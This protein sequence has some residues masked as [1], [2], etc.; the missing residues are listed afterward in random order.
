[1]T[2]VNKSDD[3]LLTV[4][5][6]T[7]NAAEFLPR[8]LESLAVQPEIHSNEV[9]VIIVDG[10]STDETLTV[11]RSFPFISLTISEPDE[12]I[13]HAMNKGAH[14][15]S[16]RWIQFLNAGDAFTDSDSLRKALVA[17]GR[18][19]EQLTPWAIAAARNLGGGKGTIRRIPNTPHTWWRHAYGL[20]PHCHQATWFRR[21]TFLD[22]GAHS[23]K[24]ATAGDFDIILRFGMLCAPLTTSEVLVDYLGGG[25][26]ERTASRS[27]YLQ[28]RVRAD[29]FQLG[30]FAGLLDRVI[31]IGI[32]GYNR[33]RTIAGGLKAS[34]GAQR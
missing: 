31:G 17:L 26:S 4:I 21:S 29:R 10:A 14:L 9:E 1:M 7:Y 19:D 13:Y 32:A 16:G 15:A 22:S 5:I 18:A 24:Y 12:G 33:A 6:A 23:L 28:H 20:Q 30:S 3:K 8:T 11:A 34:T 27:P 25:I 2:N